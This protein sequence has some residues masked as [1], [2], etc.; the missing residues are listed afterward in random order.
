MKDW[1]KKITA[2]DVDVRLVGVFIGDLR[3]RFD[4]A[5]DGRRPI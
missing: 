3:K 4:V 1:E 2:A 5:G